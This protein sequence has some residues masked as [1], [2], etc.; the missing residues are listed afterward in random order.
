MRIFK[1]PNNWR[2]ALA[3][4]GLSIGIVLSGSLCA[5]VAAVAFRFLAKCQKHGEEI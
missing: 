5:V 4:I 3:A 1:S 2:N